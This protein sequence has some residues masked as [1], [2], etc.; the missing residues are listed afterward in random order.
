MLQTHVI[1]GFNERCTQGVDWLTLVSE[2]NQQ[3]A[4]V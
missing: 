4:N 2:W 3:Q 1:L